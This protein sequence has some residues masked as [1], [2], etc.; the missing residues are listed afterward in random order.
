[1]SAPTTVRSA[2]PRHLAALLAGVLGGGVLGATGLGLALPSAQAAEPET[3]IS[4]VESDGRTV[5]VLVD[6]P[7]EVTP[8]LGE[9]SLSLAGVEVEATAEK[10]SGTTALS[11]TSILAIDTS[12]SMKGARFAAARQAASQ[13]LD[14]VPGDVKVGIV[15]FASQVTEALFPTTDRAAAR[16]VVAGLALTKQT[17]LYE[18]VQRA[19][20]MAGTQGQRSVLVLSDGADTT[21]ADITAT[22]A[23]VRAGEVSLDVVA[24]D[25]RGNEALDQLA[26]AGNG[27][28]IEAAAGNL[29]SAFEAEAQVLS[30]QV[31]VSAELPASV[32][33]AEGTVSLT[34]PSDGGDL[35]ASSFAQLRAGAS[36]P[37]AAVASGGGTGLPGWVQWLGLGAVGVGLLL[38][39]G[40]LLP[41]LAPRKLT[42]EERIT[43]YTD[44]SQAKANAGPVDQLATAKQAAA[45]FLS[46]N[47]SLDARIR[48]RLDQAGSELRSAE[49]LVVHTICVIAAI[50]LG[51]L[52]GGGSF[53]LMLVFLAAGVVLPWLYL[54]YRRGKRVKA[55]NAVL[56]DTL[57]LMSGSLAAGLS[58]AQSVDT[59]VKEGTEPM[60]GEFKR[61][62]VEARLGVAVEDALE[63]I[64]ERFESKDFAWVVMAI[65]IQRQVGGNLAELLDTVAGT[66][67]EREYLRRQVATL[68]AEGKMSAWVLGGLP[69]LFL[70]YLAL[71]QGDYVAPMFTT[72]MGWM[73]LA[74]AGLMLGLGVFWMSRLVKVDV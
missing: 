71:T 26:E 19:V 7:A 61:V 25:Q 17:R 29:S 37:A 38:V 60:A 20:A 40:L 51:A 47:V 24:L 72:F 43:A 53:F 54:G 52:I 73:M 69:P 22:L 46:R 5:R 8:E 18:G 42:T 41:A 49:W 21:R 59:I 62:L 15:T 67:R 74:G 14:T 33:S 56:P 32:Q 39:L 13:Y 30:R 44:R 27:R 65:R 55:F 50:L 31:L 34:L 2:R 66:I 16:E 11:R 4:H 36:A 58:L 23:A 6:V 10:A 70:V 1:M 28:V 9:V 63:G 48:R 57:Q 64:T 12:N 45:S 35:T 3:R 68:S